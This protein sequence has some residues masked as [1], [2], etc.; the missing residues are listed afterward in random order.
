MKLLEYLVIVPEG[1]ADEAAIAAANRGHVAY[2]EMRGMFGGLGR[3][4][5]IDL[6]MPPVL[7][8]SRNREGTVWLSEVDDLG[9]KWLKEAGDGDALAGAA[10]LFQKLATTQ[11]GDVKAE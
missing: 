2:V 6:A 8:V 10:K 5:G 3:G 4:H 7:L 1:Q 11:L 9:E